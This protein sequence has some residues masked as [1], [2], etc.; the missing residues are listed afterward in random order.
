MLGKCEMT[1]ATHPHHLEVQSFLSLEQTIA[2]VV[3]IEGHHEEMSRNLKI[4]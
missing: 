4:I 3:G 1:G 2:C